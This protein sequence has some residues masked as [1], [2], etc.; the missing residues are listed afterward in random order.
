MYDMTEFFIARRYRKRGLGTTVAKRI[1]QRF[2][3]AWEIRV[4]ESNQPARAFWR[5]AVERFAG[6][7]VQE[8]YV[9]LDGK[10]WNVFSFASLS[11][12]PA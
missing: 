1:W 6:A 4:I 12:A 9:T 3:G 11:A 7:G 5:S 2:P 10:Q 8:D